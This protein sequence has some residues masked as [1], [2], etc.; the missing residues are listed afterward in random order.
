MISSSAV[1]AAANFRISSSVFVQLYHKS[2][3]IISRLGGK[4]DGSLVYKSNFA[5]NSFAAPTA[6]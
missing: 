4:T 5:F 2:M 3:I 6:V 1:V